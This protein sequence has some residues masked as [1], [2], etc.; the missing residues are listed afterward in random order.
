MN[1]GFRLKF[2][3]KSNRHKISFQDGNI[4]SGESFVRQFLVGQK[5]AQAEFGQ[6]CN[7][8]RSPGNGC[9]CSMTREGDSKT[10][11][12]SGTFSL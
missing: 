5:F 7:E 9:M 3:W 8:V 11:H 4:P 1:I 6:V 10:C 2:L 12:F